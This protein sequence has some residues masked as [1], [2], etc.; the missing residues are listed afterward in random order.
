MFLWFKMEA[1]RVAQ[2]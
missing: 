1:I 2:M